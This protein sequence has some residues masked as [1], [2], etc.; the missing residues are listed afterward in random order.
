MSK[1]KS[2]V[3]LG[4][5]P[6]GEMSDACPFWN[7]EQYITRKDEAGRVWGPDERVSREEALWMH[8]NWAAHYNGEQAKLGTIEPGK[9]ADLVVVAGDYMKVPEDGISEL[10]VTMT[11]LSGK[12]VFDG[13]PAGYVCKSKLDLDIRYDMINEPEKMFR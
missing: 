10:P 13:G 5:K 9:L 3:R 11:M 7:M 1:V 6:V 8:T 4:F 2:Y 12:I